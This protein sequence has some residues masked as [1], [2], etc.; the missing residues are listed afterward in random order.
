MTVST[1]FRHAVSQQSM[2]PPKSSQGEKATFRLIHAGLV[3]RYFSKF[4]IPGHCRIATGSFK[5]I[6]GR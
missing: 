2:I 4:F 3:H 6:L 1:D 5:S